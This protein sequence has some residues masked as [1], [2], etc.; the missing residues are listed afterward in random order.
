MLITGLPS[1]ASWQDLKVHAYCSWWLCLM[2]ISSYYSLHLWFWSQLRWRSWW[3]GS[4]DNTIFVQLNIFRDYD[5]SFDL[6][7]NIFLN[8]FMMQ[9]IFES[10]YILEDTFRYNLVL[11]LSYANV[12]MNKISFSSCNGGCDSNLLIYPGSHAQGRRCLLFPSL[13]WWWW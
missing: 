10:F 6:F 8:I 13:Q 1:S 12:C 5:I 3:C 4:K 2:P 9:K 7:W 11:T